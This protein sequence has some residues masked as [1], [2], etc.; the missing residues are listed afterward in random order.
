MFLS[1]AKDA[2]R[3]PLKAFVAGAPHPLICADGHLL[4]AGEKG[5]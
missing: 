1:L 3:L 5:S 2:F 4:P